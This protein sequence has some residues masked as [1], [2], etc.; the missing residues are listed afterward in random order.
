MKRLLAVISIVLAGH[1]L[2]GRRPGSSHLFCMPSTSSATT[3]CGE[4]FPV[5]FEATVTY[6]RGFEKTLFAQDGTPN[7]CT[8]H[9][10]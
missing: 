6:F 10:I 7:L 5:A 2:L 3:R 1:K 9:Q 8:A 4:R